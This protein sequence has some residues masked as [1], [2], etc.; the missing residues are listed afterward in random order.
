MYLGVRV[1]L[2]LGSITMMDVPVKDDNS[3]VEESPVLL[4][5]HGHVIE[6]AES[7]R[8]IVFSVVTRGP[9]QAQTVTEAAGTDWNI[10]FS[11]FSQQSSSSQPL[12]TSSMM[13]PAAT[14]AALGV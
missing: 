12:L 3:L 7:E 1:E 6:E 13:D 14:L 9:D 2:L 10:K 4:R 5:C 11:S 8:L